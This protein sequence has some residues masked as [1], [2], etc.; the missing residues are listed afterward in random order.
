LQKL[1]YLVQVVAWLSGSPL[2]SI[3]VVTQRRVR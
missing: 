2:V 1:V 3:N